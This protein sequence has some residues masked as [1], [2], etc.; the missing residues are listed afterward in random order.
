MDVTEGDPDFD[1]GAVAIPILSAP[2]TIADLPV[3]VFFLVLVFSLLPL[4]CS[5]IF[6]W[7]AT[8]KRMEQPHPLQSPTATDM[9]VTPA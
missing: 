5:V 1:E 8:R 6:M 9:T 4:A 2:P 7:R 3:W